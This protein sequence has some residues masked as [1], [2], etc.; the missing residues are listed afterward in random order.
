MATR[1]PNAYST[2]WIRGR[3]SRTIAAAGWNKDDAYIDS[4]RQLE[5]SGEDPR[6][7]WYVGADRTPRASG[8]EKN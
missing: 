4:R 8:M 2:R 1:L 7:W 3:E 6:A 5:A